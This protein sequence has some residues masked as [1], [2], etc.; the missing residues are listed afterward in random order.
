MAMA[1]PLRTIYIGGERTS[2]V[3]ID[4]DIGMGMGEDA[5]ADAC[6]R[7]ESNRVEGEVEL[8]D[9]ERKLVKSPFTAL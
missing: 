3:D 1:H 5:D 6:G 8:A 9:R 4:I 2:G 7:R